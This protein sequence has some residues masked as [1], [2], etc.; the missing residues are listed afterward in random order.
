MCGLCHR[1][2][3]IKSKNKVKK[4]SISSLLICLIAIIQSKNKVPSFLSADRE[5]GT[6]YLGVC[7]HMP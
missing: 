5:D 1:I 4:M 3:I 6:F 2:S 7:G